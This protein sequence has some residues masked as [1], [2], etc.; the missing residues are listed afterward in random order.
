MLAE[1][2]VIHPPRALGTRI[3]TSRRGVQSTT[4]NYRSWDGMVTVRK[5]MAACTRT[6]LYGRATVR[7]GAD[8]PLYK[9]VMA[10]CGPGNGQRKRRCI[11]YNWIGRFWSCL[12]SLCQGSA[13]IGCILK[14]E[15]WLSKQVHK[16]GHLEWF[17]QAV[18][19]CKSARRDP[20]LRSPAK[21]IPVVG[22][23]HKEPRH[24]TS[25]K[26]WG[27][28]RL[29]ITQCVVKETVPEGHG[30]N[31]NGSG[32]NSRIHF[33]WSSQGD[34]STRGKASGTLVCNSQRGKITPNYGLSR[35]K[36]V[37]GTKAVQAGKLVR[38][39]SCPTKRN[40]GSKNRFKARLFSSGIVRT[41]KTLRLHP[42]AGQSLPVSSSLLWHEH[43]STKLAKC[44]E[45]VSQKMEKQGNTHVGLPRRHPSGW[46]FATGS[47][48]TP[49]FNASGFGS[50]RHGGERQEITPGTNAAGGS[51]GILNR[52]KTG[53]PPSTKRKD[54]K[55]KKRAWK[56]PNPFQYVMSKDGGYI[57]RHEVIFNGNALPQGVHG[58]TRPICDARKE[59]WVGSKNRDSTRVKESSQR[60]GR[61]Y[62][63]VER[64]TVS[65]K[66][67][68]ER[69]A[70]RFLPRGM[71][72][73]RCHGRT[74]H[75]GVLEGP[76]RT[77]Y[78]REG[79]GSSHKYGQIL[80]Q[81]RGVC[82]SQSGQCRGF[83]IS[84]KGGRAYPQFKPTGTPI[85]QVVHGAQCAFEPATGK[86]FRRL[87]RWPQQNAQGQ[88]R[89]YPKS[90]VVPAPNAQ[91]ERALPAPNRYVC[92]P[93]K[94]PTAQVRLQGPTLASHRGKCP[95]VSSGKFPLLLCK[96][97]MEN[98]QPMAAQ[99][100]G[101]Q[102]SNL[103]VNNTLLGFK[104]MVAPTAQTAGEGNPKFSN[105]PILG[106]V[107]E[108]LGRTNATATM[109]PDL[110]SVIRRGLQTKQVSDDAAENYLAGLKSLPRYDR[111][112]KLFWAFC[113]VK[114]MD[115]VSATLTEVAAKLLQFD[116]IFPTQSRH[117][118]ASLLLIPGLEQLA[119]QPI[120]RQLKRKWNSSEARYVS[121][122]DASGPVATLAAKGL[123]WTS[124]EDLRTQL[125]LCMRFFMLCRN[126]DLERMYRTISFIDEQPFVLVQ[127]KGWPKPRWEALV[128]LPAHPQLCPWT[129]L[130]RYVAMTA[131]VATG[132]PVFRA[133][134]PPFA[135]LKA[136]SIGSITKRALSA[137]GVDTSVWKPHSTRGAGVTMLKRLGMSSEEVCEVGKWKNVGAFTS[138][139]L[140]LGA[141]N[142]VGSR[143][144]DMAS[145]SRRACEY[146][147]NNGEPTHPPSPISTCDVASSSNAN[148]RASSAFAL[149]LSQD[150]SGLSDQLPCH[151]ELN[152]LV[153][154]PDSSSEVSQASGSPNQLVEVLKPTTFVFQ[155]SQSVSGKKRMLSQQA[156]QPRLGSQ[157]AG[158][159]GSRLR[160]KRVKM[161]NQLPSYVSLSEHQPTRGYMCFSL[162]R[163]PPGLGNMTANRRLTAMRRT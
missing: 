163:G 50:S 126:V 58:R 38:N 152:A 67:P 48:K 104:C 139:Y 55:Y 154:N 24:F 98:H 133:L 8:V 51:F 22:I 44:N 109:A 62:A 70:L 56:A 117:A 19:Q 123:N 10:T 122:Y 153:D 146:V 34:R 91:V 42:S 106:D 29:G 27:S 136:N 86:E 93:W 81:K 20:L 82:N 132:T 144:S 127:R 79:A 84:G 68:S 112:F 90:G 158:K 72:W 80:S 150:V 54:E 141:T 31:E 12:F 131:K 143:I 6:W 111:A 155:K 11:E 161:T 119:F 77:P 13:R 61:F 142:K 78:Q 108:L 66:N 138:H 59:N 41:I 118:Y 162:H 76:E 87:G 17:Q 28:S 64:K 35:V 69:I 113:N 53:S 159:S 36:S 96:P 43:T 65:G 75:T 5:A 156:S 97:T 140:R 52:L 63:D 145:N 95:Q 37:H 107:Q 14:A 151:I 85:S 21:S 26:A 100:V 94:P 46:K 125:I 7:H 148:S 32:N 124:M 101:Q 30:R 49:Q 33:C 110:H 115:A 128:R 18:A 135:P 114:E 47:T 129:L 40:V 147:C 157:R 99:T 160:D 130:Q 74:D 89:L 88:G 73:G 23:K 25:H 149:P 137:L 116:Q 45:S 16:W 1:M 39:F 121:F 103:R 102:A 2:A 134:Q 120:L 92:L 60:N 83:F 15:E 71:G 57:R 3:E 105:T 4:R 9:K